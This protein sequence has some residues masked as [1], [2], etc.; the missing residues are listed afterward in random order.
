M[1]E[2][3]H[4]N[5]IL[6]ILDRSY[7]KEVVCYLN[8]KTCFELLIATILSAQ[9]TDERVNSVTPSLFKKFNSPEAF[10]NA[11]IKELEEA[12]RSTG[13][14]KNKAK[15]IIECSK[16][17]V[18]FYG[19]EVPRELEELIK[20]PGVGRKT[21]NVIRGNIYKIPSIVVD[22]HVKRISIRLGLTLHEDPTKI[23]FDLMEKLPEEHWIRY[24]T[25]VIAHGRSICTA[26]S[27]KCEGCMFLAYC[28]FGLFTCTNRLPIKTQET[29]SKGHMY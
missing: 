21:A 27:P 4:I 7:S 1:T 17:L 20:L 3:Q 25:Q 6:D 29:L 14:Y 28:P 22:T 10:A 9:C 15:N 11:D 24:N 12:I 5:I 26:R 8:H 19:G 2:Q 16:L 23:E 13:F 18:S